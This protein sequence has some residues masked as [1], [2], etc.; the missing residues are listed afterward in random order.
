M[1]WR[2]EF[3]FCKGFEFLSISHEQAVNGFGESEWSDAT[4]Y[5]LPDCL[6]ACLR[7]H[8]SDAFPGAVIDYTE[9]TVGPVI[10]EG[11]F[12]VV[13]QGKWIGHDVAI[14]KL[15]IQYV[16]EEY[17]SEFKREVELLSQ[18]RHR[19]IVQ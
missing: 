12:A 18:L 6:S 3:I 15:K 5:D 11:A 17:V 13:H 10:G 14:K 1:Q 16:Q 19:N 8:T 7:S 2:N 4:V 9:L